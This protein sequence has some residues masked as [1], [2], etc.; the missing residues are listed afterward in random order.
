M[1]GILIGTDLLDDP[2]ALRVWRGIVGYEGM[3][4]WAECGRLYIIDG[5]LA[6]TLL[7]RE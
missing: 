3:D 5:T 4:G 1:H 7:G 6:S 2:E